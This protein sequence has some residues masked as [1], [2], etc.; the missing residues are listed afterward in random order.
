[1]NSVADIIAGTVIALLSGMGVG[2][3]G[4]LVV[5]LT[6][7]SNVTQIEAQALNLYFFRFSSSASLILHLRRRKIFWSADLF[8]TAAG[9]IG[10]TAG[11]ALSSAL[12]P[13]LLRQLFGI[14]LI[15]CGLFSAKSA[16]VPILRPFIIKKLKSCE[17]I[18]APF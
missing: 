1:M 2:S 9:L 13:T 14:M 17:K 18:T 5:W 11:T 12:D 15:I 16:I 8:M 7:T 3:A 10:A 6:L 4:L